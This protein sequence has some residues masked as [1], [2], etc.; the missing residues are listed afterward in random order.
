MKNLMLAII[1]TSVFACENKPEADT[2]SANEKDLIKTVILNSVNWAH[3]KDY[4]L[5]YASVLNDS[6]YLEI[7]PYNRV[8]KGFNN[9]R[10]LKSFVKSHDYVHLT[11]NI[12]DLQ[13]NISSKGDA[14]WFSCILDSKNL[15]KNEPDN[16][17]NT[18]WTGVLIKEDGKWIIVQQHY[19][20][21]SEF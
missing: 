14:S 3:N 4:N 20:F 11:N 15:Y 5:L 17:L 16:W 7:E 1:L 8:V 9:F 19:S 10:D 6:N 18:R 12:S 2:I 21:A 13:I